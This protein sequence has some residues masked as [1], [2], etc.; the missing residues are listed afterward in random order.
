MLFV[1][2][3]LL[4]QHPAIAVL[5]QQQASWNRG[6]LDGFM[7]G[8]ER[9]E[10]VT[11]VGS[12]VTR[13]YGRILENYRK[14]YP[15]PERMGKLTFSEL[16][17]KPLGEDYAAIV[18]RFSLERSQAGGGNASGRFTVLLRKGVDGWK[19]IHDHTTASP[20]PE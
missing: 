2:A 5:E 10:S 8:Y 7:Q 12:R 20:P 14:S 1:L 18:G 19:I 17:A 15:T 9:S 16:E 3:A 6:D 13:G 4:L 11:F